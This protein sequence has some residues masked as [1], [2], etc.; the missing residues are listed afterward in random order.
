VI[1]QRWAT[2]WTIGVLRFDSRR[3]LGTFLFTSAASRPVLGPTQPPVL[4]FVSV[5]CF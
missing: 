4:F 1:A 3:G 2:G 5:N